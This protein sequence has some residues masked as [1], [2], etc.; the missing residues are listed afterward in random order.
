MIIL[1]LLVCQSAVIKGQE[2][3]KEEKRAQKKVAR[4][5]LK[6]SIKL[7]GEERYVDASQQL[8]S[9]LILDNRNS[10]GYYYRG[11]VSLK[12]GDTTA[13]ETTIDMGISKSPM[14]SRLKA[15]RARIFI[16]KIT[17]N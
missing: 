12:Q 11:L 15:L 5:L 8:D 16:R 1:V 4:E 17:S 7:V 3:T 2:L 9:L 13:A 6:S 14:S 10:D